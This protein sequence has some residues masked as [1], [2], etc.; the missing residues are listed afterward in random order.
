M[1][2]FSVIIWAWG[3]P[4]R[5][6]QLATICT[7]QPCGDQQPTPASLTA[8]HG[9]GISLS[10]HAS[11]TDT[12]EVVYALVFLVLAAVIFWRASQTCIGLLTV[13]LLTTFGASQT[14]SG[15]TSDP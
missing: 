9:S 8:F 1:A 5:Y 14:S 11:S 12:L 13:L 6:A 7:A 2:I 10:L 15:A 4:L 3:V